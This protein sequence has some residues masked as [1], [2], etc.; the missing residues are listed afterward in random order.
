MNFQSRMNAECS[1]KGRIIEQWHRWH[2]QKDTKS[3][4][5]N[6]IIDYEQPS[7]KTTTRAEDSSLPTT[8][9]RCHSAR[10]R[11]MMMGRATNSERMIRR[12]ATTQAATT[13]LYS[14]E[15]M[16][17]SKAYGG[18]IVDWPKRRSSSSS[19]G[20]SILRRERGQSRERP[21]K[22]AVVTF[23]EI[24]VMY[25]TSCP[26]KNHAGNENEKPSYTK[27]YVKTFR[28]KT[29]SNAIQIRRKMPSSSSGRK[30]STDKD[31]SRRDHTRAVLEEQSRMREERV[32]KNPHLM[33]E[34]SKFAASRSAMSVLKARFRV[35]LAA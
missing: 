12:P 1:D 8:T 10:R 28:L 34:L 19:C 16:L 4:S 15:R 29:N 14:S 11:M 9:A 31:T 30:N 2:G 33:D 18:L 21:T 25:I 24:S 7:T 5:D 13:R 20:C 27:K 22:V 6:N 32:T 26:S 23:S 3:S 35:A 17:G